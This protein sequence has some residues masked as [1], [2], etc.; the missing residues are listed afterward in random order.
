MFEPPPEI[1]FPHPRIC[2]VLYA[3]PT[4]PAGDANAD[5]TRDASGDE[6][7][8]FINPHDS[9]IQLKGYSFTDRNSGAYSFHFTFP[10]LSLAPGARV[11]VFNGYKA[12]WKGPVGDRARAPLLPHP[13]FGNA[14]VF[15]AKASSSGVG[16]ANPGDFILLSD[17][18]GRPVSL[19]HWGTYDEPNP[20]APMVEALPL[21][22][23]QSVH[24]TPAGWVGHAEIDGVRCSPG[25]APDGLNQDEPS[26]PPRDEV[27]PPVA[28]DGPDA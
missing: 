17:P 23:G 21:V 24:L 1:P 13:D 19:V 14:W 28:P 8:E 12:T 18:G 3:V 27:G 26:E 15:T 22:S 5:G 25:R 7:I 11:V 20:A 4:G 16:L 2:E 9:S 6:F 10:A